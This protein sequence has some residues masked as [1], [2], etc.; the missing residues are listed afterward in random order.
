MNRFYLSFILSI[1]LIGFGLSQQQGGG[2]WIPTE[3][4]IEEMKSMGLKLDADE[5]FNSDKPAINHAIA[6]FG[7]GCTS[8]VISPNGLLLTNHHCGYGQIQAHSSVE[9][10]YLTNG[11][12]AMSLEEELPNSGLTATFIIKIADVTDKVLQGID[13]TMDFER[14]Q[15]FVKS[16][17][18]ILTENT[19]K[20]SYQDT[21]IRAFYNGNKYYQFITETYR[22]VRLVGTP[23][24]AIGK[25]GGDTDNWS[26]PRHTGDFALFRIYAD[27]DNKP[28]D[29]SPDNVP[30]QPRHFLP[31]N[32]KG[33][34]EG[35]FTFVYGFPGRTNEYLPASAIDQI[36]NVE[37]PAKI[38]IRDIA[39]DIVLDKM[40]KDD[41][42]RI[43]YAS[44]HARIANYHK[45][46]TGESLGLKKSGAIQIKK[47]YEA[48]F[49]KRVNAN[50]QWKAEYGHLLKQMNEL[51][52]AR[53]PYIHAYSYFEEAI[54]MNS[55]T[56]RMALQIKQLYDAYGTS[57]YDQ[58]KPR[59][60]D[61]L[62]NI[63]KN[64]D[65]DLDQE[66]SL[67][68]IELYK[69]N[70]PHEFLP[71]QPIQLNAA[72]F[73]NSI[74]TGKKKVNGVSMVEDTD[75]AFENDAN[76]L[77]GLMADPVL[78]Q[79]AII[80]EAYE[81]KV[82]PKYLAINKQLEDLQRV[83]MKA[84][85]E[86]F[87]E[88]K[89]FPD[90][91][92]TLRVTYGKVDGY[93]PEDKPRYAP[94]TYLNEVIEKYIPGDFEFDVPQKLI[95]LEKKKDYGKYGVGRGKR[96][97]MPVNFI[98]SNHTTGG[99][100]GSPALDKDGNL[101]G[102]NFDRVW[103]GTMSDYHYDSEICRNIMVDMRYVLF[104]IDKYANAG[105]L[106]DEMKII[107]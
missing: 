79:V 63:Y 91:N 61:Y 12:W 88:K 44:K 17:I 2:M 86:V 41:A 57:R 64:Y 51:Y 70:V 21:F 43:K 84:Q 13:S 66:V 40:I 58:I 34:E 69:K 8:E 94:I 59:L 48:E 52:E 31:I 19:V 60:L 10:D 105:Y 73:E 98:A 93:K 46:W 81:N 97:K 24:N 76:L 11:F 16:N 87:P 107:Y 77:E 104:I 35:D 28:A 82:S 96:A 100:S 7:G 74:I 95:E 92:S 45:K 3:L 65:A 15:E 78:K 55:E 103:E 32:A 29:Y 89:I 20:E 47:D 18:E 71:D 26:W 62:K 42:T 27:K 75:K 99:N 33:V 68:L 22:D 102:I 90:A 80:L 50:P 56:F 6:H 53:A 5:I 67:A 101:I 36:I 9:N 106:L 25:F 54:F 14:R 72:M 4:N 85:L 83:Y 39:L 1:T 23:P 37:N 49:T 38:E 30:Y